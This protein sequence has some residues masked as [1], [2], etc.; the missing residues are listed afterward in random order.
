[1]NLKKLIETRNAK[2]DEMKDILKKAEAETRAMTPEEQERFD[3]LEAE[4]KSLKSTIAA[5]QRMV[6][7]EADQPTGS[8]AGDDAEKEEQEKNEERAFA[9]YVRGI[10]AENRAENLT[11]ADNGA[12]IPTSIANKI[13]EQVYEMSPILKDCSRYNV[14]GNLV[15]PYYDEETQKITVDYADEFSELESSSGKFQAIELKDFL[16]GALTKISRSLLTK[17]KFNLTSYVIKKMAEA[18]T[19]WLEKE[20]LM[21]TVGKIEGMNTGITQIV[22][23]AT[24][25][26]VTADDLID[27]QDEVPDAFQSGAYWIMNRKTRT[28]IRKLKDSEGNY[29]LNRDVSAKWGYTLLGKDVYTTDSVPAIT[30]GETAVFYGD[31]TGMA[32][33]ISENA[34]IQV[35]REKYAT[36]HAIGVVGWVAADAKVEHTQKLSKLVVKAG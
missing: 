21:G 30:N 33:K 26:K 17:S 25:G 34:N 22:T 8:E 1:M 16:A 29:L 36:Q 24:A 20:V 11:A 5:G 3:A 27:V 6:E 2:M 23:T 4:I 28:A 18:I 15:L 35:L 14:A 7:D 19:K 13:I 12:V 9:N 31:M 32:L 10:V